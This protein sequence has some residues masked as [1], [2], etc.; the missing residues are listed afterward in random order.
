MFRHTCYY[1]TEYEYRNSLRVYPVPVRTPYSRGQHAYSSSVAL[2]L[3]CLSIA[4]QCTEQLYATKL[5][6]ITD[7]R[8]DINIYLCI[9]RLAT[10][11]VKAE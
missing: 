1:C 7:P 11:E 6:T 9:L 5:S 2:L 4:L 3:L 10:P 8:A